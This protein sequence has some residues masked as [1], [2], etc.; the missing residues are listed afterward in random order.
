MSAVII[1]LAPYIERRALQR[2]QEYSP[3][4][5]MQEVSLY[6]TAFVMSFAAGAL[7]PNDDRA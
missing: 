1:E 2:A 7:P 4:Q 3:Q 6:W 5:F